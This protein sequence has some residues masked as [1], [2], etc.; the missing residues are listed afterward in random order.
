MNIKKYEECAHY[1]IK[2]RNTK[3]VKLILREIWFRQKIF[4]KFE[5]PY[6]EMFI[7]TKCNLKCKNCSNLIPDCTN[8]GHI[9]K[10]TLF[11]TLEKLLSNI[12]RLYRLKL[13]G[14]EVF[15]HPQFADIIEYAGKQKK[16]LSF[17]LTTNGTIIPGEDILDLIKRFNFIVQISDYN[18]TGVKTKELMRIFDAKNIRYVFFNEQM[19]RDMG[20]FELRQNNRRPFCAVSRCISLLDE[21]IYICSRAAMMDRQNIIKSE[22]VSIF[23]ERKV[24]QKELIHLYNNLSNAAC[25]HCDGDSEFAVKIPAGIQRGDE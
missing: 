20:G 6:L 22:Y 17:R 4:K 21:K 19:W 23:Q 12:D 7:T 1:L 5:M 15:L 16:I 10:E 24:F 9:N 25:L 18:A 14:G 2:E 11:K 3:N 13:H 8:S